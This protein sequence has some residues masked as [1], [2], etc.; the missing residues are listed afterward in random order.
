M[1]SLRG[2]RTLFS[3]IEKDDDKGCILQRGCKR[4]ERE[5]IGGAE[6]F[7]E[8]ERLMYLSDLSSRKVRCPIYSQIRSDGGRR[9]FFTAPKGG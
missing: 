1:L 7:S 8:L 9:S 5:N 6:G 3:G 2:R 4:R